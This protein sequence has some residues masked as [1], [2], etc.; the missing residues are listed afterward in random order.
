MIDDETAACDLSYGYVPYI[1]KR[2]FLA[3]KGGGGFKKSICYTD[4]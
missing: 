4:S 2:T 1:I 3:W